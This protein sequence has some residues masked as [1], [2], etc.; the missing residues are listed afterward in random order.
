MKANFCEDKIP[1][2]AGLRTIPAP[3]T[4]H[5]HATQACKECHRDDIT[6][7]SKIRC[8]TM[9]EIVDRCRATAGI[10][11]DTTHSNTTHHSPGGTTDD[12]HCHTSPGVRGH[13]G[14][15]CALWSWRRPD[16][17]G[18][19]AAGFIDTMAR[20]TEGLFSYNL[21]YAT[22]FGDILG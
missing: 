13:E 11:S 21:C 12:Q 9:T 20:I 3:L 4:T 10:S 1:S 2:I 6:N 5:A 17:L 18:R 15:E 19:I 22:S 16:D 7:L 8:L 14:P